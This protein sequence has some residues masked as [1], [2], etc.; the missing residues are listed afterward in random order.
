MWCVLHPGRTRRDVKEAPHL[1]SE[2]PHRSRRRSLWPR[3][4]VCWSEYISSSRCTV[5]GWEDSWPQ[6]DV[7]LQKEKRE[8]FMYADCK[9]KHIYTV[10]SNYRVKY[11]FF[12]WFASGTDQR[13]QWQTE[14]NRVDHH[15]H[16]LQFSQLHRLLPLLGD[17]VHW[18]WENLYMRFLND[19][20]VFLC[21]T[22]VRQQRC[23]SPMTNC[24]APPANLGTGGE[25][26]LKDSWDGNVPSFTWQPGEHIK[27]SWPVHQCCKCATSPPTA[28]A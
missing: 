28:A 17:P 22:D 12:S 5:C 2:L 6:L 26:L 1:D 14:N 25:Q 16:H 10:Y 15:F 20:T 9:N 19:N 7:C 8:S 4:R 18:R 3:C 24:S 21:K 11:Y 27:P 13:L 23:R